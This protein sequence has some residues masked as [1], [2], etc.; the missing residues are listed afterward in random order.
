MVFAASAAGV[1]QELGDGA[2]GDIAAGVDDVDVVGQALGVIHQVVVRTIPIPA[3]PKLGDQFEDELARLR[4]QPG[5]RFVEEKDLGVA[6]QRGGEGQPLL[7]SAGEPADSGP[8][9]GVDAEPLRPAR[10]AAGL[11]YMPAMWRSRGMG[12]A[13]GGGRRPAASPRRG[14]AARDRPCPGSSPKQGM[15]PPVCL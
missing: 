11:R 13:D 9:E 3:V 15:V 14:T 5:A 7:L 6:D 1:L 8:A 4:V 10:R 2:L 12:R